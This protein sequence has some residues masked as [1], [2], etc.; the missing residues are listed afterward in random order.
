MHQ[1]ADGAVDH[2]TAGD[3][4]HVLAETGGVVIGNEIQSVNVDSLIG[5][6]ARCRP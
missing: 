3:V 5:G 4:G 6:H 1:S 2:R